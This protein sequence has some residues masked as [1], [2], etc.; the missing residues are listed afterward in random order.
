MPS[1]CRDLP[2]GRLQQR[3]NAA[4]GCK[5]LT[6]ERRCSCR[7]S[8]AGNNKQRVPSSACGTSDW[9]VKIIKHGSHGLALGGCGVLLQTPPAGKAMQW[10]TL[11]IHDGS[12]RY[13]GE[14]A[15]L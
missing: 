14:S 5:G 6:L 9:L 3:D 15:G 10:E 7:V 13:V 1:Q 8:C 4:G 2:L 11:G 12:R